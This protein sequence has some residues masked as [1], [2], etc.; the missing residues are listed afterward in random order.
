MRDAKHG[1]KNNIILN[2]LHVIP[3]PGGGGIVLL[4]NDE[5]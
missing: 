5:K 2:D 4:V 3:T 1:I